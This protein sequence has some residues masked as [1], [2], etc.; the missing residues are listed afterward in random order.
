MAQQNKYGLRDLKRE[1]PNDDACLDYLFG[2][3]HT[4]EC[5]CGGVYR[6]LTKRKQ[7]QCSFCRHQIAPMAGT[8]FEKS[9]TPLSLWFYA[10]FV[11]SNAKSGI[12]GK[13]M[14]RHLNVTYKTAWRILRLIRECLGQDNNKLDGEVEMDEAYYSG[15]KDAGKYNER[16]AEAMRDKARMIGAVER[17]GQLRVEHVNDLTADTIGSFIDEHIDRPNTRLM[18]DKSNRYSIVTRNMRR[19]YV[20]HGRQ[21][22]VLR[23]I[24]VNHIESFWSHL[25]RSIK[26]THKVISRKYL[27]GYL[28]GFVWHYNNRRNDRKRFEALLLRVVLPE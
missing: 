3:L 27:Q 7:Y 12:S 20:D 23:D 13:Q 8:I 1:F 26:G 10:I 2:L 5:S 28:D 22:W 9:T 4:R 17:G 14:E 24:H 19:D 6:R 15:V 11:F 16:Q 21:Q 25:K 18:T